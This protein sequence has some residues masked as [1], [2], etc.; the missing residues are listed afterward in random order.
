MDQSVNCPDGEVSNEEVVPSPTPPTE[1]VEEE[2]L[3][4]GNESETNASGSDRSE[5]P[6]LDGNRDEIRSRSPSVSRTR[7]VRRPDYYFVK[8]RRRRSRRNSISS[9]SDTSDSENDIRA[10]TRLTNAGLFDAYV[11]KIEH[12]RGSRPASPDARG[13]RLV[14]SIVEYVRNLET[15]VYSLESKLFE[16]EEGKAEKDDKNAADD[17]KEAGQ[18]TSEFKVKFFPLSEEVDQTGR[19]KQGRDEIPDT[20]CSNVGPDDFIRVV[21]KWKNERSIEAAQAHDED[22][23]LNPE[24][25]EVVG[26]RIDSDPISSFFNSI[27]DFSIPVHGVVELFKP[28]RFIIRGLPDIRAHIAK[29]ESKF[30]STTTGDES[31]SQTENTESKEQAHERQGSEAPSLHKEDS[32]NLRKSEPPKRTVVE[33]VPQHERQETLEHFRE[34]LKFIEKYL[35]PQLKLYDDIRQGTVTKVTFENLWMVFNVNDTIYCPIKKGNQELEVFLDGDPNT[36]KYVTRTRSTPQAYRVVSSEGGVGVYVDPERDDSS[37]MTL[38]PMGKAKQQNQENLTISAKEQFTSLK[39]YCFSVDSDGEKYT[40]VEDFFIFK[41]FEGEID[42]TSLE[43]YPTHF[44]SQYEKVSEMLLQRGRKFIEM[45]EI[46]HM[47]YEGLTVGE[48][49]EEV[50]SSVIVDLKLYYQENKTHRPICAPLQPLGILRPIT[51]IVEVAGTSTSCTHRKPCRRLNCS[52]DMYTESFKVDKI[53]P[54]LRRSLCEYEPEEKDPKLAIQAIKK[55]MEATDFIRLLPGAI[56]GFVLRSRKWV[57]LDVN[58]LQ[59]SVSHDKANI[60]P[61]DTAGWKDLVLPPGYKDIV[62]AMV[63]NHTAGTRII[64]NGLYQTP[65]VDLVKGKGKGCIILIHGAPGVGKTSTA[66]CVAA[67]TK[68]PL[69]P[70][71]C[72]DVGYQPDDVEKNLD[73]VFNLAH[74]WGCV[75]LLDEADVF[76]AKRNREDIKRNGLV[77]IF[78]RTLEYYPGILFLTTNR[79]GAIDDAFRSRL[80]LTL[81]YPQ[82]DR[83]QSRKIWKVNFR[84][85]KEINEERAK[86]DH[87]PIKIDKEKILRYADLNFEELHWNGRQI[88]NAFQSALALAEFKVQDTSKSPILSVEQFD[89]IAQASHEFDHYLLTT[90]GFDEDKMAAR[91]KIRAGGSYKRSENKKLKTLPDTDESES[92]SESDSSKSSSDSSSSKSDSDSDRP[93]K[94]KK[95][96]KKSKKPE[97]KK[98]KKD[99]KDSV[100]SEK[101]KSK[102]KAKAKDTE[103]SSK[104]S[105][106]DD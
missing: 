21:Y 29:L 34:L 64:N 59:W 67:Y 58:L 83:K 52:R 75:L 46:S 18:S 19:I 82:L 49:K 91:D 22:E 95:S 20:Y 54:S 71:T 87:P 86:L 6:P 105:D 89:T 38:Q 98:Q 51:Q 14:S 17:T 100:K 57:H 37:I 68:R 94:H 103:E 84:R 79:V 11:R 27:A 47:I 88:R 35:E 48:D 2:T 50:L 78:L 44:N 25:I 5:T 55:H 80:H 66:E 32:S 42:I 97:T 102:E 65:E 61:A 1:E 31:H 40:P 96:K 101:K 15:R 62:L 85:L 8:E 70:I 63:K 106:S 92:S 24:D 28:F 60:N 53:N 23:Q 3:N 99:K 77:S 73:R 33:I 13:P 16:K 41:P 30:G 7:R 104:S 10:A 81:Y 26:F 69:F 4:T 39:V 76:L 36:K 43:A 9:A 56:S 74:R 72:G 12:G 45:T 93:S 90:H